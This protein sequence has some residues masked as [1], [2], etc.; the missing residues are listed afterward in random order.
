M[1]YQT[2]NTGTI[3]NN[4][5][6]QTKTKHIYHINDQQ[7]F[8]DNLFYIL[9]KHQEYLLPELGIENRRSYIINSWWVWETK[10]K[11]SN[12]S[13]R[14]IE[15]RPLKMKVT[16]EPQGLKI[17]FEGGPTGFEK[18]YVEDLIRSKERELCICAGT[19]NSYPVVY[20][21]LKQVFLFI[22]YNIAA[23]AVLDAVDILDPDCPDPDAYI[24]GNCC[25]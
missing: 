11:N 2:V 15:V 17:E 7:F 10:D 12:I 3:Y 21:P 13:V 14:K 1:G 8:N 25:F 20:V 4:Y 22:K 5:N 23:F 9:K 6:I 18:Y 16:E 24:D 19:Y